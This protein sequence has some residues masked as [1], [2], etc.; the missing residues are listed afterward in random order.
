MF[1]YNSRKYAKEALA[2]QLSGR[3]EADEA[4]VNEVVAKVE[5]MLGDRERALAEKER[6]LQAR[7]DVLVD[8]IR[9]TVS[10]LRDAGFPD[11]ANTIQERIRDAAQNLR[12]A[13]DGQ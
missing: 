5:Q 10:A 13:T 11:L 1:T 8:H 12:G 3:P 4:T 6:R 9:L 7:V 2:A